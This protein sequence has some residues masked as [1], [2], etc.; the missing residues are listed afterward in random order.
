[1]RVHV[2]VHV[3]VHVHRRKPHAQGRQSES[4]R[5]IGSYDRQI[6]R[7]RE[8]ERGASETYIILYYIIVY[9]M[10]PLWIEDSPQL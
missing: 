3:H 4:E 2:R 9:Y 7:Q 10:Q 6:A 8:R 1:M 5:D